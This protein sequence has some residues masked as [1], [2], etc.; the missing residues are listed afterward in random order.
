MTL[1]LAWIRAQFPALAQEINSQPAIFFDGPGGTQVP[2]QVIDAMSEYLTRSNANS[3]GNFATSAR[4]DAVIASAHAAMADLLGCASDEVVFGPNMT[5]LTFA[6]SR[7]LSRELRSG[8]EIVVTRLDHDANV[9]PWCALEEGGVVVRFVDINIEDCTLNMADMKQQINDRTRLVA[10]G[11]ASNAVG[12]I[13]DVAEVVRLAHAVGALIFVDAVHYA[14]HGPLDVRALDCDFL[15]CSPYKF[16]GPHMGVLYGKQSHLTRLL[17][18]KVRPGSDEIPY[19]WE[20]GTQNH[21]GLA[22]VVA[23]IDYLV[24]L[25]RRVLPAPSSSRRAALLAA[26]EAICRYE[27]ELCEVL[28][29][30]MLQIPGLS[31]YGISEGARFAWRTPTVA[32]RLS[33]HTPHELASLL[34]ERGIFT[35]HGNYYAI[36]LTE[37]L[38]VESSGGMLRVGLVH[39]NTV[40]EVHRLLK[41][42]NEFAEPGFEQKG[43]SQSL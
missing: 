21:E 12:T 34:G 40:E 22:G 2:Q 20:T 1:D 32:I 19:R 29:A 23:A 37:R 10:V 16:F 8:D 43:E 13:N 24:E 15:A 42:L 31:F 18:Y 7:S 26:M 33:G 11:Y 38:G 30:G 6:L 28:V 39:Y 3:H 41:A 17:P 14:P 9:A 5:T 25:G 4:T 35:W 36:N 27:R